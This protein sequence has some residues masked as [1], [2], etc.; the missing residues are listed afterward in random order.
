MSF[1]ALNAAWLGLLL[2]P[3]VVFY[4]LKLKRPRLEIPSLFLW[5]QVLADQ[6]VNSPFQKFKRNFLLLLQIL[7]LTL[8]VLA[9]MQPFLRRDAARA[10]RLPILIDV[11]ASMGALDREGGTTRL[12]EVKKRVRELIDGLPADQELSLIAFSKNARRLTPFTNNQRDLRT[13]LDALE[14]EDLPSDLEEAL[15]MAQALARTAAFDRVLLFSDGNFPAKTNFELPFKIDFQRIAPAGSNHGITSTS[16]RRAPGGRWEVFVQLGA[17]PEA[18]STTG[19]VEVLQDGAVVSTESVPLTKGASPRLAF[20]LPSEQ[21]SMVHAR[22]KLSGFDALAADNDAWLTLPA[23]RPLTIYLAPKLASY[24][25]ALEAI[26]GIALFPREGENLPTSFDLVI[27]DNAVDL[28]LPA[29]VHASIGL[30]PG[31]LQKLVTIENKNSQTI[32]WRRDAPLLQHVALNDVIFMDSPVNAADIDD[33]SYANLG[34]E[35]LA[36]GPQGPLIVSRGNGGA[37]DIALLFHTDRSTLP[38]RVGF[39][40]LV[41]NLVQ[42]AMQQSGLAE[43]NAARTGVLPPVTLAPDQSY[44]VEGPDNLRREERT[45][46]RGQLTGLP[47]PKA[48]EY[49]VSGSGAESLRLGASLLSP[50]ETSLTAVEQIEFNDKLTVAA[51]TTTAKGDRSLWWALACAAFVILLVEWWWFQR[52]GAMS[53]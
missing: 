1:S 15:R 3:L 51:A 32:D 53:A 22:L 45:D 19:T 48:G 35:I 52:R 27:T 28:E 33:A 44:R 50:S 24:R 6:R 9:A 30:I 34:Y 36:R 18:E 5:R 21:S 39:P 11:S 17:A 10:N 42:L 47:A 49:V 40:I 46:S 31:D 14:I 43:A 23:A 4:F 41:S 8:L 13:A 20:M 37:L 7:L 38:Y 25:Q 26:E 29:R 12:A 16:A 2:I